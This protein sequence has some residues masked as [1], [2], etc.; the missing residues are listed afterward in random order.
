MNQISTRVTDPQLRQGLVLQR[1]VFDR[2]A[3]RM[4]LYA[5]LHDDMLSRPLPASPRDGALRVPANCT[6][7]FDTYFSAFFEH[8]WRAWTALRGLVLDLHLSG[9]GVL[10]VFRRAPGAEDVLLHEQDF[11]EPLLPLTVE[12]ANDLPNARAAGRL[13]FTLS[14]KDGEA[15]LHQAAWRT[16]DPEEAEVG[17]VP[18]FCTFNR[19]A[20]L[21]ELLHSI[22][23]E[24]TIAS[25]LPRLVIVNQGRGDLL[26]H[27][28]L[29]ALPEAFRSKLEVIEQGN[30]GGAGGFTRGLLSALAM[31][32]ATHAL[33]M[34]DDVQLEPDS[35]RRTLAFFR[36]ARPGIALGGQMLD[37]L[38]PTHLFEAGAL[39]DPVSWYLRPLH[40]DSPLNHGW[41]L[42]RFFDLAP[43]HYNGWWFFAVP[44]SAVRQAGLPLPCFIRGDDVEYGRRLHELGIYTVSMPGVAIWH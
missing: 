9:E 44:L 15:Q 5:R 43:M 25:L 42:D 35:L 28:A 19:E 36:L 38:R 40:A 11:N 21:A 13:F 2:S 39:I 20:A 10:R 14:T 33:L 34:D 17:L 26:S 32:E 3:S 22:A 1:V 24:P 29:A 6:A 8:Q 12:I 31:P 30:F 23:A 18:I 27:P 4:P 16:P 7:S 41:E 37:L